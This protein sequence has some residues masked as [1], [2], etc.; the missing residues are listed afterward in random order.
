MVDLSKFTSNWKILSCVIL[1][2]VTSSV[3]W[4]QLSLSLSLSLYS[5]CRIVTTHSMGYILVFVLNQS[6]Q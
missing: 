3:T 6:S 4:T 1:L 5:V 2:K